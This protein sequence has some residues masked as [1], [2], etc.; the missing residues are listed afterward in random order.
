M[1]VGRRSVSVC[2][3]PPQVPA[4]DEASSVESAPAAEEG[5]DPYPDP[6]CFAEF[7]VRRG[8]ICL[9]SEPAAQQYDTAEVWTNGNKTS[10]GQTCEDDADTFPEAP[11]KRF[12]NAYCVP[13]K[14]LTCAGYELRGWCKGKTAICR[15]RCCVYGAKVRMMGK[16][17]SAAI[18][19]ASGVQ[20]YKS[21]EINNQNQ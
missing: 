3:F 13:G 5:D 7:P 11:E 15:E 6:P 12:D 1:L 20:R 18:C 4:A 9:R 16:T 2:A 10:D 14:G 19:C 17:V 21:C 8:R